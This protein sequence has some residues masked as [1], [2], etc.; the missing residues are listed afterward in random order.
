MR[1]LADE[2][3]ALLLAAADMRIQALEQD[4]R[5]AILAHRCGVAAFRLSMSKA[6]P[7][8]IRKG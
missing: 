1:Q 6:E 3:A 4:I 8:E 7:R 2:L 5:A